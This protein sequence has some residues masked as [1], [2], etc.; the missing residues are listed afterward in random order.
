M[1][2]TA[3]ME[4]LCR[5]TLSWLDQHCSL[6]ALRP[7]ESRTTGYFSY[8]HFISDAITP[9]VPCCRFASSFAISVCPLSGSQITS[10]PEYHHSHPYRPQPGARTGHPRCHSGW[11]CCGPGPRFAAHH[12]GQYPPHVTVKNRLNYTWES[13]IIERDSALNSHNTQKNI[14]NMSV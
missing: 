10:S 7:S 3:S 13:G 11:P 9:C 4:D 12:W 5:S 14:D 2:S 6:P 8:P 1:V